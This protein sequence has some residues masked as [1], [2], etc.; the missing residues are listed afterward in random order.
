MNL[1]IDTSTNYLFLILE[2]NNK[3]VSNLKLF[4][5]KLHTE[6]TI[7]EICKLLKKNNFLW[8]DIKSFYV[9]NGPGSYTGVRVTLTI[10]KTIK[11]I[12]NN[13][14]VFWINS[15]IFQVGLKNQLS[16]IDA[17]GNK[18]YALHC[19]KGKA[20]GKIKIID[21]NLIINKE[22]SIDYNN[23]DYTTNYL[24]LKKHFKKIKNINDLKPLYVKKII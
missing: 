7:E 23:I 13:V 21:K 6:Q 17:R 12:N 2:N 15:L 11:T 8:K 9:T 10:V 18:Y 16:L 5:K 24:N 3:I 14:D 4:G 22:S 19:N 1:F 20:T